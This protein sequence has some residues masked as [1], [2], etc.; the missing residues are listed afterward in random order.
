M[1]PTKHFHSWRKLLQTLAPPTHSLKLV[2]Y[3]FTH[4]PGAFQI[5]ASVLGLGLSDIVHWPFQ[6]RLLVSYSPPTVPALSPIDFQNQTLE[7][8]ICRDEPVPR[9]GCA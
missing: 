4:Y 9:D 1:V 6:S 7:K 3:S 2:S 8:L 5:A